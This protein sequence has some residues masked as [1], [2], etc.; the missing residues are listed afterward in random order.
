MRSILLFPLTCILL[1]G[2]GFAQQTVGPTATLPSVAA[3]GN[4]MGAGVAERPGG[5][6]YVTRQR[7]TA[8][9]AMAA[10]GFFAAG[11]VQVTAPVAGTASGVGLAATG[12]SLAGAARTPVR[13]A[14]ALTS[15]GSSEAQVLTTLQRLAAAGNRDAQRALS[16]LSRGGR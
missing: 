9:A 16:A 14:G 4:G 1:A 5:I 15:S 7:R 10:S 12:A 2:P 11:G 6:S 8:G 3:G 13:T